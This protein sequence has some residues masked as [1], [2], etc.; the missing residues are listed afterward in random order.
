MSTETDACDVSGYFPERYDVPYNMAKHKVYG[1]KNKKMNEY[2]ERRC[3]ES[4]LVEDIHE[5]FCTIGQIQDLVERRR[6]PRS[7][8]KAKL[9][10]YESFKN[11]DFAARHKHFS[12]EIPCEA[13]AIKVSTAIKLTEQNVWL[14]LYKD[15]FLAA[16]IWPDF[17]DKLL[18]NKTSAMVNYVESDSE[19]NRIEQMSMDRGYGRYRNDKEYRA[20][21]LVDLAL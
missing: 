18:A 5:N 13:L 14:K 15:P 20:G 21:D 16:M 12:K 8:L 10:V 9:D 4:E 7:K 17:K 3:A 11:K 19:T 1:A 6:Q 2:V